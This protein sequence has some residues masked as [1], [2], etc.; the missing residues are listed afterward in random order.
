MIFSSYIA[1]FYGP[2][3]AEGQAEAHAWS[4]MNSGTPFQ[5]TMKQATLKT[6]PF[7]QSVNRETH[8]C[9]C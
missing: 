3:N 5:T 2:I 6:M 4:H 1:L 7:A 8:L 9:V